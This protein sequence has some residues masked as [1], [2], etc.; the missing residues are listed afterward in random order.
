MKHEFSEH[1]LTSLLGPA[2]N[3]V[4]DTFLNILTCIKN[5][6]SDNNRLRYVCA[7][8]KSVGKISKIAYWFFMIQSW[9]R[10]SQRPSSKV[11]DSILEVWSF[12]DPILKGC[13][14][15]CYVNN[16]ESLMINRLFR[17]TY[18]SD[19]GRFT[20]SVYFETALQKLLLSSWASCPTIRKHHVHCHAI[21]HMPY[22]CTSFPRIVT[23][24][25]PT[26]LL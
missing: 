4:W 21:L 8:W 9:T 20:L 25:N 12:Q 6:F 5:H 22:N 23:E 1:A 11:Q 15:G 19:V 26:A 13:R 10:I 3:F 7:R 2:L 17:N 16:M 24:K 18:Y 14:R